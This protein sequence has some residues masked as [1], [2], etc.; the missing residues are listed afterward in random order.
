[1]NNK[2]RLEAVLNGQTPDRVPFAP[3]EELLPRTFFEKRFRNKGCGLIKHYD[4]ITMY[5]QGEEKNTKWCNDGSMI[6]T[7][8]TKYGDV[9]E[10]YIYKY[11]ISNDG[12]VQTEFMIKCPDDYKRAIAVLNSKVFEV[13][14]TLDELMEYKLGDEGIFHTW[15]GEPPYMEAQYLLGFERWAY[16]QVDEPEKF[17]QLLDALMH[18]QERRMSCVLKSSLKYINIANLSGNFSP[19]NFEKYMLPYIREY[20]I[21]LREVGKKSTI[22]CDA[23]NLKN[24]TELI[25]KCKIDI[26]EAFTPAP[27][28][29]MTLKDFRDA[30]GENITIWVNFPETIFY[31]GYNATKEYTKNLILSD[32]CPNKII[33][34]TEMGFVGVN[35]SNI[36][37]Y[38]AGFDAILDAVNEYGVYR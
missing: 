29:D 16:E 14:N 38:E 18:V 25:K 22:H 8:H 1:M 13:D 33:G 19:V 21:K 23:T 15:T 36:K 11:G 28:G 12:Y 27:V 2:Q 10:R 20:A 32:R 6:H 7:Y 24:Y 17:K 3:F 31:S 30:I 34:L 35:M 26:V 9:S 4:G 37:I 5:L